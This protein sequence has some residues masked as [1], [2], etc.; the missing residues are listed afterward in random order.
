[1]E[2][3]FTFFLPDCEKRLN[4]LW[5]EVRI[6][7]FQEVHGLRRTKIRFVQYRRK[8]LGFL[9]FLFSR[10]TKRMVK[11]PPGN[12][13][14]LTHTVRIFIDVVVLS[15]TDENFMEAPTEEKMAILKREI[16]KV[17]SNTLGHE[18]GHAT[19]RINLWQLLLQS[20]LRPYRAGEI[21]AV[22]ERIA[23]E[24]ARQ[25]VQELET[26]FLVGEVEQ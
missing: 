24:F 1:M 5:N 2:E 16:P 26:I 14:H 20:L 13:S 18:F 6:R 15:L 25:H 12:Y 3:V 17:L 9:S 19:D 21:I 8:P 7:R 11:A 10:L 4:V 23:D 22:R